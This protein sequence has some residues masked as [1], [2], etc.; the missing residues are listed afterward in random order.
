M[1]EFPKELGQT[2]LEGNDAKEPLSF[3]RSEFDY[4][5]RQRKNY[6]GYVA[7]G[8]AL[9]L[10]H[11]KLKIW[12]EFWSSINDGADVFKADFFVNGSDNLDKI[13]RFTTSF[14]KENLGNLKFKIKCSLEILD[15][16]TAY[17]ESCP[18]YPSNLL[19]PSDELFPC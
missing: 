3:T 1:V 16:G 15:N 2:L 17:A 10:H 4:G 18:V 11:S 8:F 5:T 9:V 12:D 7:S 13:V 14:T 6:K 19:Y